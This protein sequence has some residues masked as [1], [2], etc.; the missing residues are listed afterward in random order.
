MSLFLTMFSTNYG[1]YFSLIMHFKILSAIFFNLDQSNIL[2]SGKEL[3][4]HLTIP[5][6][7]TPEEEAFGRQFRGKEE[8]AGNQHFLLF[9]QCFL[10]YRKP[11]VSF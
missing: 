9:P 10:P 5:T 2:L 8:N 7:N 6:V 4:I 3:T 11:I 1:T